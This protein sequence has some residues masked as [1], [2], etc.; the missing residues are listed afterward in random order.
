MGLDF[1]RIQKV[2]AS[3]I[4]A[5]ACWEAIWFSCHFAIV[6]LFFVLTETVSEG[7]AKLAYQPRDKK[8]LNLK[9]GDVVLVKG[10]KAGMKTDLWGGEVSSI[11]LRVFSF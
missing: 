6:D 2:V 10:K 7:R 3:L 1:G 4:S 9:K 5:E 11:F 8:F